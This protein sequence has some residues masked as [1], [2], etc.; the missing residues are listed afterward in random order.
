VNTTTLAH[1]HDGEE[2]RNLDHISECIRQFA[3]KRGM[4][5]NEAVRQALALGLKEMENGYTIVTSE[6]LEDMSARQRAVLNGLRKGLAVKEIADD[7]KISEV[8]V[9]T[10]ILRIRSRLGCPDLL[11]LRM[12]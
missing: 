8:T 6:D 11:K 4:S 3:L 10:H 5:P 9:R 2:L 1:A 7:L 12:Q